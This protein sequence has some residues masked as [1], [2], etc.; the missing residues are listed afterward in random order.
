MHFKLLLLNRISTFLLYFGT[1]A[2]L[3]SSGL[4]ESLLHLMVLYFKVIFNHKALRGEVEG[5]KTIIN[6]FKFF[7]HKLEQFINFFLSLKISIK[8]RIELTTYKYH[9]LSLHTFLSHNNKN[10]Y[11]SITRNCVCTLKK[12]D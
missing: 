10:A 9:M 11:S 5:S 12:Q 1:R 2:Y 3:F 8:L 4:L 6:T 7:V